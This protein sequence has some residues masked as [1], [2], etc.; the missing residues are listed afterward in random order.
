MFEDLS[1]AARAWDEASNVQK[2]VIAGCVILWAV[3]LV[4]FYYWS[5]G[6]I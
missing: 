2:N 1:R 4:E 6:Q 5:A 3:L